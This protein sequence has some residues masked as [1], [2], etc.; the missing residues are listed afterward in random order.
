MLEEIKVLLE[1]V[2][3]EKYIL[4]LISLKL[5]MSIALEIG[6]W[7]I[8]KIVEIRAKVEKY[9]FSNSLLDATI[10]DSGIREKRGNKVFYPQLIY[11]LFCIPFID[12]N[13]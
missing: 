12:F 5:L 8:C 6:I 13:H 11:L 4:S 1:L 2:L 9:I 3:L 7:A 10:Q